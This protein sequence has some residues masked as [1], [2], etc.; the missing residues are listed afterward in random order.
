MRAAAARPPP[1]HTAPPLAPPRPGV[2]GR[3][4]ALVR[5]QA[6]KKGF[7]SKKAAPKVEL[8]FVA[9]ASVCCAPRALPDISHR[10]RN[11][12]TNNIL[13]DDTG[14]GSKSKQQPRVRTPNTQQ[15]GN[16][17]RLP[18]RG[19]G[20]GDLQLRQVEDPDARMR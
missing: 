14:G 8:H 3:A 19:G 5:C 12:L 1:P 10:T 20:L 17:L 4:R 11:A 9:R 7:G 6:A 13:Q 18:G 2:T 15:A 16:T